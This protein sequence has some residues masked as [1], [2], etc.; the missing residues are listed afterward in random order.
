MLSELDRTINYL[1]KIDTEDEKKELLSQYRLDSS[2]TSTLKKEIE[3]IEKDEFK[4]SKE[5]GDALEK[6]A[7]NI[8]TFN[9]MFSVDSNLHSSTNEV[10]L[11]LTLNP[12]ARLILS[13]LYPNLSKLQY[14]GECKN[15]NK[16]VDVT[17]V[18]KVHSLLNLHNFDICLLFSRK[19]FTGRNWDGGKGLSKKIALKEN[20][21]VIDISFDD[22]K[23]LEEVSVIE[24]I[25]SKYLEIIHDI[26]YTKY[27][28]KHPAETD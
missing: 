22:I 20:L 18:G 6:L 4:N 14:I 3:N 7:K 11:V 25:D 26:D 19:G 17:W 9:N 16:K 23:S 2:Y 5:K 10:D 13:T 15:Y 21:Y 1:Q 28:S 24:L 12:G 27:L 8:L